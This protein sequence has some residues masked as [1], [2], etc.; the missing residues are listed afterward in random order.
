[1]IKT[2]HYDTH[3]KSKRTILTYTNIKIVLKS[4]KAWY[5]TGNL[6][7]VV[8]SYLQEKALGNI[9]IKVRAMVISF[10]NKLVVGLG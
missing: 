6:K 2:A 10:L 7:L 8:I 5:F 3:K 9:I 4:E 1:M